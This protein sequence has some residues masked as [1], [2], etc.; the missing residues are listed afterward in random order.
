MDYLSYIVIYRY[1]LIFELSFENSAR[2]GEI[3][4]IKE[5]VKEINIIR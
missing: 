1:R 3:L 5:Y 4:I 2:E